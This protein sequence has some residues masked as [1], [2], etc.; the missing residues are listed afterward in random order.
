MTGDFREPVVG[1]NRC[2]TYAEWALE[3]QTER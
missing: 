3:Q 2:G 1:V